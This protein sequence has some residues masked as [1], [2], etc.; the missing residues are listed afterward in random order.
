[1]EAVTEDR[2]CGLALAAFGLTILGVVV[3]YW[4]AWQFARIANVL[5]AVVGSTLLVM[6]VQ[7]MLGGFLIAIVNGN[8]ADIRKS[9]PWDGGE[10]RGGD[11]EKVPAA[12]KAA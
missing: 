2:L 7:T 6:G 9:V 10:R 4:S 5:P 8:E 11:E 1:M 3:Y 12:R